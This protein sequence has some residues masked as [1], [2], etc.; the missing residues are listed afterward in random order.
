M[1]GSGDWQRK[2]GPKIVWYCLQYFLIYNGI[3]TNLL[4]PSQKCWITIRFLS[5]LYMHCRPDYKLFYPESFQHP[6]KKQVI[7]RLI[8]I[9]RLKR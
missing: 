8:R 5:Q 7:P 2:G 3:S 1:P 9:P 6:N 4:S